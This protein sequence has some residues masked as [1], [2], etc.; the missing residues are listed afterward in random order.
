MPRQQFIEYIS[1]IQI[2]IKEKKLTILVPNDYIKDK[3]TTY[4]LSII[5]NILNNISNN[6]Y[7]I[8]LQVGSLIIHQPNKQTKNI[9]KHTLDNNINTTKTLENFIENNSNNFVKSTIIR[10]IKD[11]G[12][13][14]NPLFFY[15]ENGLGKT[16]LTH[17]IANEIKKTYKNTKIILLNTEKFIY[18]VEYFTQNQNIKE[19][20]KIYTSCNSLIIDDIHLMSENKHAQEEFLKILNILTRKK[21]QVILTSNKLPENIKNLNQ[22]IKEKLLSNAIIQ[23]TIPNF[24]ARIEIIK[25][26]L[27]KN[28]TSCHNNILKFIS[29]KPE[30]NIQTLKN[31]LNYIITQLNSPKAITSLDETKKLLEQN[32]KNIS[33][34]NIIDATLKFYSIKLEKIQQ[35]TRHRSIVKT[36]Q[37]IFYLCKKLT[38]CSL[39]EIGTA[40]GQYNHTTVLYSY[41][42][43]NNLI[44]ETA[45]ITHEI[46]NIIKTLTK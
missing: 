45:P 17:A 31:T 29:K 10:I 25:N 22:K 2:N 36:R 33:I 27:K 21:T 28:N 41:K 46:N 35:K 40:L 11:L 1:P 5:K 9:Y 24:K 4:Y 43:I 38:H 20:K 8:K 18:D 7:S 23:I 14:Y 16:H 30:K 3:I 26:E 15:G 37:I 32:I 19:L 12:H 44:K 6:N 13:V 34:K 42:K 39:S